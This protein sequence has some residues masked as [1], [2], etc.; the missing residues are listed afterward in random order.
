[1]VVIGR[2]S[3]VLFKQ[4]Q[5]IFQPRSDTR[6]LVTMMR[7]ELGFRSIEKWECEAKKTWNSISKQEKRTYPDAIVYDFES[8]LDK[9]RRNEVTTALTCENAYVPIS[10]SIGDKL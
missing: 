3:L 1:M 4:P 5:R 2:L 7:T 9:T 8:Y 10:V 6:N